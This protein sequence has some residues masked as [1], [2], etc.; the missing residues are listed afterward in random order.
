LRSCEEVEAQLCQAQL[1]GLHLSLPASSHVQYLQP[2]L[3]TTSLVS[4][5]VRHEIPKKKQNNV[6]KPI[7]IQLGPKALALFEDDLLFQVDPAEAAIPHVAYLLGTARYVFL[8][9]CCFFGVLRLEAGM[10]MEMLRLGQAAD[11]CKLF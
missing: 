3:A 5:S 7:N 9:F 10:T 4:E 8:L 1:G 6:P 11:S 2:L